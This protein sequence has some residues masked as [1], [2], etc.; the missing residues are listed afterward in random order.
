MPFQS[1]S[2][3]HRKSVALE[4]RYRNFDD[5]AAD[6]GKRNDTNTFRSRDDG[7]TVYIAKSR[8]D[9][10]KSS[11][12]VNFMKDLCNKSIIKKRTKDALRK[13]NAGARK[14]WEL[15]FKGLDQR[16]IR[17]IQ[18]EHKKIFGTDLPDGD[19]LKHAGD[20][21]LSRHK[22][23]ILRGIRQ[24]A[25]E[26]VG[27]NDEH[28]HIPNM[29][30]FKRSQR[31]NIGQM[32]QRQHEK[33][34]AHD[35]EAE[36]QD[37]MPRMKALGDECDARGVLSRQMYS[38]LGGEAGDHDRH[39]Y[40]LE[41]GMPKFLKALDEFKK[42]PMDASD[43]EWKKRKNKLVGWT[44]FMNS[45]MT[46]ALPIYDRLGKSDNIS[47]DDMRATANHFPTTPGAFTALAELQTWNHIEQY[48]SVAHL[49]TANAMET[50]KER[51]L[52]Y[53]SL[54]ENAPTDE[55][56]AKFKEQAQFQR[57]AA[58]TAET[59][60]EASVHNDKA[61]AFEDAAAKG[62]TPAQYE[63]YDRRALQHAKMYRINESVGQTINT[64]RKQADAHCSEIEHNG[65]PEDPLNPE[66]FCRNVVYSISRQDAD[67]ALNYQANGN[68]IDGHEVKWDMRTGDEDQAVLDGFVEERADIE[69][70]PNPDVPDDSIVGLD[71]NADVGLDANDGADQED[72]AEDPSESAPQPWLD[73]THWSDWRTSQ[74]IFAGLEAF[75]A[76]G[77][78]GVATDAD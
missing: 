63:L 7:K 17:Y 61:Q 78:T 21:A 62:L 50:H 23:A 68:P 33:N 41:W 52:H 14:P 27:R 3:W 72:D 25:L 66:T 44:E 18:K 70:D 34:L 19:N 58:N 77:G 20:I 71:G 40:D 9:A 69:E 12:R 13:E 24:R 42:L 22:I 74:G 29:Q 16:H 15:F 36:V 45:K 4:S 67:D 56:V 39:V 1:I 28:P 73:T 65:L 48:L 43:K 26:H 32:Q 30:Q 64:Y 54:I 59:K 49:Q 37:L 60:K 38:I 8:H 55:E 10:T 76:F 5:F 53:N 2:T 31:S 47:K 46:R 35:L 6:N 11:V 75:R 57:D 51:A